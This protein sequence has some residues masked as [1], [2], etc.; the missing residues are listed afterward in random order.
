MLISILPGEHSPPDPCAQGH[1]CPEMTTS[2]DQYPCP[3][4][5]FTNRSD[6]FHESECEQCTAGY[7]CTGQLYYAL[8]GV[9]IISSCFYNKKCVA[10]FE[11]SQ[12]T[13]GIARY[14]CTGQLK[15]CAVLFEV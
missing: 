5:T 13:L 15:L 2:P 3:A 8:L 6:L 10:L 9:G 1:Y 4:G 12:C 7:Y 11:K 14:Y